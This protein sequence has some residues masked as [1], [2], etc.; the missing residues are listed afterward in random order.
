MKPASFIRIGIV[1][2]FVSLVITACNESEVKQK[3]KQAVRPHRLLIVNHGWH[4]GVILKAEIVMDHFP[5][6]RDYFPS[7]GYLEFGWGDAGFYQAKQI[8]PGLIATALF[9]ASPSVTHVVSFRTSPKIYFFGA[10]LFEIDMSDFEVE[11]LISYIAETF[12]YTS[13]GKLKPGGVG[14]YGISRFFQAKYN[15]FIGRTCN[16]WTAEVLSRVGL[17]IGTSLRFTAD[18]VMAYLRVRC[19][20]GRCRLISQ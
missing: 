7:K 3:V 6:L 8:T 15:Y 13:S 12:Q 11:R 10:E 16:H 4:T 20:I 1:I 19:P 2:L 18:S 14:I 9:E 5:V 17:P